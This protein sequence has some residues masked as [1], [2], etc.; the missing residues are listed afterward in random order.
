W[1]E[2]PAYLAAA[3]STG[4]FRADAAAEGDYALFAFEDVN[5]NLT[6]DVGL[7]PAAVG[8]PS[9]PLRPSAPEQTLRLTALDTLPLRIAEAAFEAEG[10][11]DTTEGAEPAEF[12]PGIVV[13]K[14]TR[15]PHPARA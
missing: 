13:V 10:P 5:G 7:E 2:L 6:F 3:D 12:L 14:F 1:R 11:A 4:A 15:A 9:L 8:D